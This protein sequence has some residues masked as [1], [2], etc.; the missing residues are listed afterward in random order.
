VGNEKK[1]KATV[2]FQLVEGND[3]TLALVVCEVEAI[4]S[5]SQDKKEFRRREGGTGQNVA[6][7]KQKKEFRFAHSVLFGF[8]QASSRETSRDER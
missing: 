8:P 7:S 4:V 5:A 1:E 6:E 2:N 3:R